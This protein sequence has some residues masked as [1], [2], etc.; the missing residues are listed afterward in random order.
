[1][2][3]DNLKKTIKESIITYF[4]NIRGA[5]GLEL[6][7][8]NLRYSRCV[9]TLCVMDPRFDEEI[10]YAEQL[11]NGDKVSDKNHTYGEYETMFGT[12]CVESQGDET[13]IYFPE[14]KQIGKEVY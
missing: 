10:E 6:V 11:F 4:G 7:S 12:I 1:M 5:M 13:N 9:M 14:E 8:E 3:M 2:A